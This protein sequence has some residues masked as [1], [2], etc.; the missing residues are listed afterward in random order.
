MYRLRTYTVVPALPEPL[1]RLRDLAYNF[2]WCWNGDAR[3]LFRRLDPDLWSSVVHNPV[4]FLAHVA[5]HRL[6]QAADDKAFLTHMKRVLASFD[7]Y[8]SREGW[9]ARTFP[10]IKDARIGYFSMEFGLHESLPIYSG[11]LGI[12]A[13]DHLK[14]ASDLGIPMV[15]VGLL[16]RHG[17]F[18]QRLTADGW[19]IEEYPS[20]DFYQAPLTL[21]AGADHAPVS[22]VLPIGG[23]DVRAQVWRTQVGR[24]PLYLLD[25]D[26][27]D[28]SPKDREITSRLYGGD[29]E[30][31][32]RQEILL[33]IGGLRALSALGQFPDVCHMNE[34]HAGFLAI[35]HLQQQR[36]AGGLDFGEARE[37]VTASL[38]FTTHTPIPA[39]IDTFKEELLEKYL[40]PFLPGIG[41]SLA[42]FSAIGKM[43]AADPKEDFNMAVMALRLAGAANGVSALHGHVSREM[44]HHVW[45]GA[46]REEVPITS[47]TNGI[48]TQTWISAEMA[49]LLDRYIGPTWTED[50]VDHEVW[51][52]VDDIPDLELWRVHERRRIAMVSFA[53]RRLV[54]QKRRRGAPLTEL[55]AADQFLDPDA[56]TIGF[57]RRFAPYKR[58]SLLFQNMTRLMRI[59]ENTERPVQFIFAGKAHPRD[60]NGK[61]VIKKIFAHLSDPALARRVIFLENYDIAVARVL[62]QGVDVW[63][64]NPIKP[65]EASGT[66][67]MKVAPNGGLNVSVLD[68]WWPEAFDGANGW[69]VDEGQIHEDAEYR[70]HADSEAIYDLLEKEVIPLFYDRGTDGVPR[71]WVRRMKDGMKT[72]CPMFNTNRM[73][74]EYARRLYVPSVR[75]WRHLSADHYAA[76]K[77]LS[78]WKRAL[79]GAWGHVAVERVEAD[80]ARELPVGSEVRVRACVQLGDVR[81]EDVAV[82]LFHG[83]VDPDGRLTEGSAVEMRCADHLENGTYWFDGK[84][85]CLS[86]GRHGYAI[87]VLPRHR[88]LTHRYDT[89]L[90]HWS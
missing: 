83:L 7:A 48:H 30:M 47:I 58:G 90:I 15:G 10:E 4:K 44:W 69:A 27:P 12:L 1:A 28:N 6:N 57:A 73:L 76:A 79:S 24:V 39:G 8:M 78:Q 51:R 75:R 65:R 77:S 71:G 2:W 29:S 85:P 17:Y 25:T 11:G 54:E 5:Q 34:G 70:D 55:K 74:E 13:G 3:E 61:A 42:E 18:Q 49:D 52:R 37:A 22:I 67:G 16:Y 20:L 35:E 89:G 41:L 84:I 36:Q 86:S 53:R 31:R 82:E 14:S 81:P 40:S 64:N 43:N 50:P 9:F 56:L 88:D 32:I 87:R 72:I 62:V 46:P 26:I 33:G 45:P 38:V 63:L 60:E 21:M 80:D 59:L 68:G 23:R 19:Q 66:S